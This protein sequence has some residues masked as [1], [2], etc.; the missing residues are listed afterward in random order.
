MGGGPLDELLCPLVV[1]EDDAPV[2]PRQLDG[3]RDDGGQHRLEIERG[4]DGASHLAQRRE[5]LDRAGEIGG[6]GLQLLEQP[7]VLDR[8]DGLIREGLDQLDLALGE[9]RASVRVTMTT[10]I[11]WSS[12]S[13]GAASAERHP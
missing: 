1:L 2:E 5:L 10:P 12:L 3:A 6:P 9:A 8:D 4:A 13:I 11:T 7:H